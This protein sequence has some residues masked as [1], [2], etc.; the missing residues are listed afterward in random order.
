MDIDA[1]AAIAH[2]IQHAKQLL[3][4]PDERAAYYRNLPHGGFGIPY[5]VPGQ[6][7]ASVWDE[8]YDSLKLAL[9]SLQTKGELQEVLN[10]RFPPDFKDTPNNYDLSKMSKEEIAH[11]VT[12]ELLKKRDEA[13]ADN[14]GEEE[15]EEEEEDSDS[16]AEEEE[17]EEEEEEDSDSDAE[18]EEEEEDAG[19]SSTTSARACVVCM[20]GIPNRL[21]RPCNH[22]S[23]CGG[24]ARRIQ[25]QQPSRCPVCRGDIAS[26]ERVFL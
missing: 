23:L 26:V 3:A 11:F 20:E 2:A 18:E 16:D 15:E 9:M 22:L 21:V 14:S 24:C 12:R 8:A 19:E 17:E 25:R 7:Y 1:F 13:E 6:P 5:A 10:Y 4:N